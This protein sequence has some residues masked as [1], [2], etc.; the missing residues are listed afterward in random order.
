[1]DHKGK[2]THLS[3]TAVVE[4]DG[5]LLHLGLGRKGVPAEVKGTITEVTNVLVSCSWDV[6]HDD[7]F[8]EAN[9]ANE[10]EK[11]GTRDG[12]QGS[13][14]VG[15]ASEG[16]SGEVNVSRNTDTSLLDKVSSNGKHGDTSVLDLDVTETV[17]LELVTVGND[18]KR[19]E[20]AKGGL[21]T[22]LA[23]ETHVGSDRGTGD[24][25][26]SEGG[27]R[28]DEGGDDNRLHDID[29]F[30]FEEIVN[31]SDGERLFR[32]RK[33]TASS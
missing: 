1:V 33:E 6:L 30:D 7:K 3:G 27:G 31:R 17:E 8:E 20:E 23:I 9:E 11:T 21:G 29:M 16:C 4:L 10:L 12:V 19:V 32:K 15:D 25:G 13:E 22:E 24:L 28:G 2:D 5:T 18:T 14:A 26:R